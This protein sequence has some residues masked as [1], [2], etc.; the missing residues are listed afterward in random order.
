[1]TDGE[2]SGHI[3]PHSP[4]AITG[5]INGNCSSKVFIEGNPAAF[6]GSTTDEHDCCCAGGSGVV[7]A[8]SSKVFIEGKP[9][10]R[11]GD[12]ITPHNGTA[13]VSQGSSK[14]IFG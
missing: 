12:T 2:H 13:N 6:V 1:M 5:T 7:S 14:V 8:G 10:V 3:D 4:C 11:N 9:A